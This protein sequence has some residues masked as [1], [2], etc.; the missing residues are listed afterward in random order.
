MKTNLCVKTGLML[1]LS[2][3]VLV[4][5]GKKKPAEAV[6][7]KTA[8]SA[9]AA[10]DTATVP[11][12]I[13]LKVEEPLDLD[14]NI[15]SLSVQDLRILRNL[16]YARYGYLF[17]EADLRDY[18]ENSTYWYTRVME[19]R[20][21]AEYVEKYPEY[22]EDYSGTYH[23]VAPIELTP[24]EIAFVERIDKRM[25]VLKKNDYVKAG[26]YRAANPKNIVNL[27][28]F[29]DISPEFMQKLT[30][31]NIVI[32]PDSYI[33][34]FHIY[35]TNDYGEIP[36]FITTD[37]MLQAFHMYFSYT[38]KYL[39][40]EK[41]IPAIE[42]LCLSLY[43]KS[44]EQAKNSTDEMLEIAKYNATFYAIPY[45][46]LSQK[47]V[48]IPENYRS[49]YEAELK[50]IAG[51]EDNT[52]QFLHFY[53]VEFPYS[54]F[55]PRGNY[56]RKESLKR[57]F[58]A[59]Q[60]LQL[61]CY[62]REDDEQ[63][64]DAVFVAA[65]LSSEPTLMQL[66]KSVYEP[67]VFLVGESDNL[68]VMDIAEFFVKEKISNP[69]IALQSENVEKVNNLLITTAKTRNR[70]APKIEVSCSDKINFMPARYLVD[71][72]II[73]ELVDARA[74]AKRAYPKGLD[75][76]AAF[77]SKP[78]LNVLLNTCQ[79]DKQWEEYLPTMKKLQTK[80]NNYGGWNTSV[81]N[82]WVE[83]LLT[84]QSA[85]KSYP[86][87]MQLPAWD[88][89]NLNT[90][91][92][93]W[94]DLKHDAILY[95]EQPM[96]AECGSGGIPPPPDPDV[97]GYVEPNILFWKKLG[98]LLEL[99]DKL[100]TSNNLMTKELKSRTRELGDDVKFLLTVSQKE[101]KKEKLTEAEYHT[102]EKFG[103]SMEYFTR[104]V[105]DPDNVPDNWEAV[106]GPDKSIAIVADIYTRN[107]NGCDKNGILHEAVGKANNLYV[108]V[109]IEGN[110]YLT[111]GATFSYYEFVKPLGTR[112]TDEEWQEMLEKNQAPPV[113]IWMNTIM[114]NVPP[115]DNATFTYSS[116]C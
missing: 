108:V 85:N 40:Q 84:L 101:L 5:C 72:E 70:I 63:L 20:W 80:F 26:G 16:V 1:C 99:T 98:E 107:A 67:T 97:V 28:Q 106:K 58:R 96:L 77:G 114:I 87:F 35:E 93:S 25:A 56:T 12:T 95:S 91:L 22:V 78:A 116:G 24:D 4:S 31:N 113:P 27:F 13:V 71:N 10:T 53:G 11:D 17:M 7:A 66:Y 115:T 6:A 48:E 65:L 47:K 19:N 38:L 43:Q 23:P 90:S 21:E 49:Q 100:L 41:F 51:E 88:L 112:L 18:F 50:N 44:M 104:E 3:C 45:Y 57:Y 33:Q 34:L 36:S 8:T 109:E 64:R 30:Q 15:D 42:K 60:W 111:R 37:L 59:M 94:T 29:R 54:Q 46:L 52:S 2:I 69:T 103:A 86:E 74:N 82:K 55:K 83:S 14:Q 79:E 62:C 110:L 61:A 68:S 105:I 81:Y 89:K 9:D 92:A 39:E 102:I 32:T 73:Q 76:F 75:V